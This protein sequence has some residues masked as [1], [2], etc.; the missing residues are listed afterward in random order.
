MAAR[1]VARLTGETVTLQ[2]DNSV[3]GMPDLRIDYG[4]GRVAYGEV[5]QT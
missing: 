3:D 4:D 1:V 5:R 2:D